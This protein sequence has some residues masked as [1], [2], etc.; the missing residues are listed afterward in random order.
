MIIRDDDV[1]EGGVSVD[2]NSEADESLDKA[3]AKGKLAINVKKTA[4]TTI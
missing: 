1:S 3:L 4:L 2:D